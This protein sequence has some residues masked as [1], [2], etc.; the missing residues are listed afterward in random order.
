[1][2]KI[3][4]LALIGLSTTVFA[5]N[6]AINIAKDS[7][8][9]S[10]KD[11]DSVQFKELR[12][13]TNT[14]GE[15]S[16]CGFYNAK[17]SY[18]GYVGYEG[19]NSDI[20]T[21]IIK[22]L[23]GLNDYILAG[24]DG[25][26]AELALRLEMIEN[27]RNAEKNTYVYARSSEI[28]KA[29]GEFLQQVIKKKKPVN[30][31]FE[32]IKADINNDRFT[33]KTISPNKNVFTTRDYYKE[34]K[35]SIEEYTSVLNQV[36]S[37]PK[38]IVEV[39][40]NFTEELIEKGLKKAMPNCIANQSQLYYGKSTPEKIEE[41]KVEVDENEDIKEWK[42]IILNKAIREWKKP[43]S[44]EGMVDSQI[45][46]LVDNKGKLLNLHW[47]KPTNNRKIDRSIVNAF[48]DSA[49][50]PAPPITDT[51]LRVTITFP[52]QNQ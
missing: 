2:K 3:F 40:Y 50:F 16:I 15:K 12:V 6:T 48:K 19:F 22:S 49:P 43:E 44:L 27:K 31:A 32:Q 35:P 20:K 29:H 25:K 41:H 51:N 24:C 17:N 5:N 42:T 13:V 23:E 11:P 36:T 9:S 18:G 1:M 45:A 37:D 10:L 52:A 8:K 28:C 4:G 14:E 46:V 7:I 38:K 47:V 34:Y 30:L 39:K 33:Y 21:G 26:K